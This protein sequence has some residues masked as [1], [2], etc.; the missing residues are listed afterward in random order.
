MCNGWQNILMSRNIPLWYTFSFSGVLFHFRRFKKRIGVI[1]AQPMDH[2]ANK[3]DH[4]QFSLLEVE[5][6]IEF[7]CGVMRVIEL[8][9]MLNS[10]LAQ[11]HLVIW[12]QRL[13]M[14]S[15][16]GCMFSN[17]TVYTWRKIKR[18]NPAKKHLCRQIQ[19]VPKLLKPNIQKMVRFAF[20]LILKMLTC[21]RR[22]EVGQNS[23][24]TLLQSWKGVGHTDIQTTEMCNAWITA[25]IFHYKL[26][27]LYL[28]NRTVTNVSAFDC[29]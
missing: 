15:G 13:F 19:T 8:H 6:I 10:Y 29:Q 14:S 2:L 17:V 4:I 26:H 12:W 22:K 23:S 25:N 7:L 3:R 1:S 24:F 9:V 28:L 21:Y 11:P 16:I 5:Q 20:F 18:Q 27:M